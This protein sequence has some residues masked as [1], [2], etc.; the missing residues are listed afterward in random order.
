MPKKIS[1][2][3]LL[4]RHVSSKDRVLLLNPP[5]EETR[6]SWIRWN[7]PTDLLKIGGFLRAE[8]GC[9]A[10]LLDLMKPDPEGRVPEEWLAG[11]RRYRYVGG[12]RYPMRRFGLSDQSITDWVP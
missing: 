3:A 11:N 4:A 9:A 2:K 6:Y 5:V 1:S 10:D 7:Q 8:I 12:E